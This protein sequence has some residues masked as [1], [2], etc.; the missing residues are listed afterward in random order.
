MDLLRKYGSM[1]FSYWLSGHRRLQDTYIHYLQC[2]NSTK[3]KHTLTATY[4]HSTQLRGKYT[5][6]RKM[7]RI[8]KLHTTY[9]HGYQGPHSKAYVQ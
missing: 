3:H 8:L 2:N 6:E 9:I 4:L 5:V 7:K 1:K